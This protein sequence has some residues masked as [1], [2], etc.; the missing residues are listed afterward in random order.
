MGSFFRSKAFGHALAAVTIF[1]WGMTFIST[2]ILL[3]SFSPAEILVMRFTIGYVALAL[4]CP[5]PLR[6]TTPK[7]EATLALAGLTGICLYYFLENTA[8][9]YTYA[10]NTS[11]IVSTAPFFTAIASAAASHGKKRLTPMFFVGF[12]VSMA[13]ICLICFCGD[14]VA[15][16]PVGDLLALG[17][18]VVWAFY[19]VAI[20]RAGEWGL[21]IVQ[22]TR[23][24]FAYGIAF[25][26]PVAAAGG[27]TLGLERFADPSNTL[28]MLFLGLVACAGCFASWNWSIKIIG[29]IA[30]GIYIYLS[31]VVT[32]VAAAAVLGERVTAFTVVGIV[33]T[34]VGLV[35]SQRGN[36]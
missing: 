31:P 11:V 29:P 35:V 8:L 36:G 33:L 19:S 34:L 20:D 28:N 30:S 7:Q 14:E 13:G 25:M 9:T 24:V 1:F 6:A 3:V 27:F 21:P 5:R 2:K 22:V 4:A 17:G 32:A 12:A 16:S 15:F 18:A 26:V 10:S 23:R